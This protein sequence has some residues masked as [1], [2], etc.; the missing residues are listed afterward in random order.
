MVW[1]VMEKGRAPEHGT[2]EEIQKNVVPIILFH[3]RPAA[4]AS[5]D[6]APPLPAL[7]DQG[8]VRARAHRLRVVVRHVRKWAAPHNPAQ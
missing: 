1:L 3:R 6:Y 5:G 7:V 2:K 8:H 4:V